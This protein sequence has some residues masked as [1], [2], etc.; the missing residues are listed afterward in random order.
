MKVVAIVVGVLMLAAVG[1]F[2]EVSVW[3]ECR[4]T[5]SWFFCLRMMSK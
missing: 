1:I 4:Q 3:N 5:N 2:L